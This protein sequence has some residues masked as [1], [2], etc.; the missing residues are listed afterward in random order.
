MIWCFYDGG[1]LPRSRKKGSS[2][3]FCFF[4]KSL[5]FKLKKHFPKPATLQSVAGIA[6]HPMHKPTK[7]IKTAG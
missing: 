4:E 7:R 3:A 2:L 1:V 5:L 6:H